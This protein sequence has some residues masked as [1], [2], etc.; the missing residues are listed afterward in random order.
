MLKA[1][2]DLDLW[3]S[4]DGAANLPIENLYAAGT[5]NG[6]ESFNHGRGYT[7]AQRQAIGDHVSMRRRDP[8]FQKLLRSHAERH[9]RLLELLAGDGD[10]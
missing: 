4:F 2:R 9:Q 10:R 8:A 1:R 6:K 3:F 7:K 5:L